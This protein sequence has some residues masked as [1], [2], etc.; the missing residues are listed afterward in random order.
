M[1]LIPHFIADMDGDDALIVSA[2]MTA[3]MSVMAVWNATLAR[4][5]VSARL[6]QLTNLTEAMKAGAVAPQKHRVRG[7]FRQ[8][9]VSL[10]RHIVLRFNLMR[11]R[12]LERVVTKLN[13][14]GW[15]SKDAAIIYSFAKVAAPVVLIATVLVFFALKGGMKST[16][17]YLALAIAGFAG[18]FGT[19]LLVKNVGDNRVKKLTLALPDALDLLVIC[20][21]AGLS[22]DSAIK[23]VGAE[24]V[25]SSREMAD[26][27]TLTGIELSFLP[28][29][30]RALQN[31]V[32]RTDVPKLRAL[33]NSLMQSEKFGTPLANTL[34]V[35]S[36]EFRD[37]RMMKAEEKAAKLPAIMTIPMILFIL[38]SLFI[39]IMGPAV[40][41]IIDQLSH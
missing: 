20:A 6:K 8:S 19:D 39:V 13:R 33:V 34:R 24:I 7:D 11:G 21:E 9:S 27:L 17:G 26:E 41:H 12:H 2:A 23:R 15:R 32:T 1:S 28:D 3:W 16:L 36:A 18:I 22:L 5:P 25:S 40:I 10:I 4:D 31:L 14:A 37:E 38:P 30:N 35:L 29:R